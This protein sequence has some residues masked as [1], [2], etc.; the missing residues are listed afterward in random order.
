MASRHGPGQRIGAVNAARTAAT[1]I[2]E[3]GAFEYPLTDAEAQELFARGGDTAASL[4]AYGK[5]HPEVF[6]GVWIESTSGDSVIGVTD[7]PSRHEDAIR[8]LNDGS[9]EGIQVVRQAHTAEELAELQSEVERR[10]AG[11]FTSVGAYVDLNMVGV[12]LPEPDVENE[13][14]LAELAAGGRLCFDGYEVLHTVDAVDR[15]LG[16]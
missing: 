16:R 5:Q 9:L 8:G 15:T 14:I 1:S 3:A 2:P 13:A 6:A 7:E 10:L 11:R 12:S 4:S